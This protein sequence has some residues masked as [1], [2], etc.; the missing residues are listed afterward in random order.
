MEMV[1]TGHLVG[2]GRRPQSRILHCLYLLNARVTC[3]G[4]AYLAIDFP[5]ALHVSS[6]VSF[7]C[8][9]NDPASA[10]SMLFLLSILCVTLLQCLW[11]DKDG[12]I[13]TPSILG[14]RSSGSC[15]SSRVISGCVWN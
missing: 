1:N 3:V 7:S 6:K 9:Q 4:A 11:K 8:S 2:P 15:I 10:F 5:N 12:S 13:I 14:L